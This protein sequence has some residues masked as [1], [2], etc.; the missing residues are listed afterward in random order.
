MSTITP[1]STPHVHFTL[2][3]VQQHL[4]T[5][6]IQTRTI[7]KTLLCAPEFIASLVKLQLEFRIERMCQVWPKI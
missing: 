2:D 5:I 7:F 6:H 4:S 1:T 3:Q